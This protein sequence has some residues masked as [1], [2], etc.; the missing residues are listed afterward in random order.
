VVVE[1]RPADA[2]KTGSSGSSVWRFRVKAPSGEALL[3]ADSEEEMNAWAAD[4]T[5]AAMLCSF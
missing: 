3:A 4:I 2:P 1:L 5:K